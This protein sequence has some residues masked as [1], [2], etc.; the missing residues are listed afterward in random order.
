MPERDPA[1]GYL[2][3]YGAFTIAG[4][5]WLVRRGCDAVVVEAGMGGASDESSLT[6]PAVVAVTQVFDDHRGVLGDDL[7]EI[8][9]D[10]ADVVSTSTEV[11]VS[12][13]QDAAVMRVIEAAVDRVEARLELV[14]S[15]APPELPAL[16]GLPTRLMRMNATLG[17]RAAD[18]LLALLDP[19][20]GNGRAAHELPTVSLP[21]R[22]SVHRRGGRTWVVDSAISPEAV[23]DAVDWCRASVGDPSTVLLCIPDSKD[24]DGCTEAVR[25]PNVRMLRAR[26]PHMTFEATS[27]GARLPTLADVEAEPLGPLVLAIGTLS[28][29][30]EVLDLLDVDMTE[31]FS[32]VARDGP[33]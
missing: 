2:S 6:H 3:P 5:T 17:I 25:H 21:G 8:A 31:I 18:Q 9:T 14:G 24:V 26:T 32:A 10:K 16:H 7:V 11:V 1:D 23:R 27:H 30:A 13:P 12:V 15:D 33:S 20:G 22:L 19:T 28:F 29:A 4:L